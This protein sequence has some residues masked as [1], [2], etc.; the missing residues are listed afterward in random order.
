MIDTIHFV[1][2]SVKRENGVDLIY[3]NRALQGSCACKC[4]PQNFLF[5]PPSLRLSEKPRESKPLNCNTAEFI[6]LQLIWFLKTFKHRYSQHHSTVTCTAPGPF[7]RNQPLLLASAK[8]FILLAP[9][10]FFF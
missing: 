5:F 1:P 8:A 7:L 4:V 3:I 2:K 6:Y 10:R 9:Q